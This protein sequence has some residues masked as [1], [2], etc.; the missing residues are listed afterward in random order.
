VRL[1]RRHSPSTIRLRKCRDFSDYA[2]AGAAATTVA[3]N[4]SGFIQSSIGQWNQSN[5]AT[6]FVSSTQLQVMLTAAD[7]AAGGTGQ[8]VVVNPA[9]GGGASATATFTINNPARKF[10][11]SLPARLQR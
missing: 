11:E 4:G 3:V 1:P 2:A 6:T 10:L 7:L 8:I 5:R 9:P